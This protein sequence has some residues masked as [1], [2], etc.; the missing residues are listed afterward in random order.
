MQT[1]TNDIA[2]RLYDSNGRTVQLTESLCLAA[3]LRVVGDIKS[4]L[5]HYGPVRL[6]TLD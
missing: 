1:G 6:R 5:H 4:R 3:R 2:S